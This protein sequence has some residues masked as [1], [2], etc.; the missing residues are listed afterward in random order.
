MDSQLYAK[1]LDSDQTSGSGEQEANEIT[2]NTSQKKQT[3]GRVDE[4]DGDDTEVPVKKKQ[5][6][7]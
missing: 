7:S 2:M 4:S 1:L 5:K 6:Y 3:R